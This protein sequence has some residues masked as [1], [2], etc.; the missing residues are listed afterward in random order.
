MFLAALAIQP[1]TYNDLEAGLVQHEDEFRMTFNPPFSRF[2]IDTTV[3]STV[4][5]VDLI[6]TRFTPAPTPMPGSN[7]VCIFTKSY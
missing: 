5:D 1:T 6:P 2:V 4:I 3:G 7:T